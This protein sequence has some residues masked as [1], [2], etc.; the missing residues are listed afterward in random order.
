MTAALRSR[1]DLEDAVMAWIT[2]VF[3]SGRAIIAWPNAPRPELPYLSMRFSAITDIGQDDV[4]PVDIDSGERIYYGDRLIT[5]SINAYGTG[6]MDLI[7]ALRNSLRK[8]A[9]QLALV[10]NGLCSQLPGPV[11]DLTKFLDSESE[12]RVHCD[13]TFGVKDLDTEDVGVIEHVAGDGTIR[14]ESGEAMFFDFTA[15][16]A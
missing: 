7:R 13:I 14:S 8:D 6:A 11:N 1:T 16:L 2:A 3:P 12:E 9:I 10:A 4:G 15:D 5:V